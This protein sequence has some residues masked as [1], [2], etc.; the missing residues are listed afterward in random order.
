M[1]QQII[2]SFKSLFKKQER[3][4]YPLNFGIIEVTDQGLEKDQKDNFNKVI[5]VY[6]D[7]A[8]DEEIEYTLEER[9]AL[10]EVE[11]IPIVEEKYETEFEFAQEPN[12]GEVITRR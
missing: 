12:F 5:K 10:E 3:L 6:R 8:Y 11:R 9:K 4:K 2:E 1:F 7:G